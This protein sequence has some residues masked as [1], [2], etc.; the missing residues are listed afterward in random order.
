MGLN[1]Q[2]TDLGSKVRLDWTPDLSGQGYRLYIDG[3][4]VSRTFK[5]EA[6]ST[7]FTKPDANPHRY[8]VQKMDVVDALE[9]VEW[10][11]PPPVGNPIP[12]DGIIRAGGTYSGIFSKQ[13]RIS[14]T[15]PVIF[16]ELDHTYMDG[17]M[18][19]TG[20]TRFDL[21][22]RNCR[23]TGDVHRLIDA[24]SFKR[25]D[26]QHL[27]VEKTAGVTLVGDGDVTYMYS[28]H[29]NIQRVPGGVGN[30]IQLRIKQ[31]GIC[32]LG[33]NEI[34]NEYNKSNPEDLVSL[35]HSSA[36]HI[37]DSMFW[38]QFHPGNGAG[39]SQNGIT[40]DGYGG[41]TSNPIPVNDTVVERIQVVRALS[42]ALFPT[43]SGPVNRT[44]FIDNRYVN[45]GLLDDGVT[46]NYY[47]YQGMSVKTGGTDNQAHGNVLGAM[48]GTSQ[49]SGRGNDGNFSGEPRGDGNG[50]TTG[51]WVDN[52]HMAPVGG[53][54]TQ[55]ME[56][57]EWDRWEAKKAAAG[58]TVGA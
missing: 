26:L 17:T 35:Y 50:S 20:S 3:V 16:Q 34:V 28:R 1:P 44:R 52:T 58:V 51:A 36:A 33:W 45:A 41:S 56:E 27:T 23:F 42:I 29:H 48:K 53:T 9:E 5:P 24:D 31:A 14:T 37:F 11:A 21:T 38:G 10:P 40:L 22:A 4:A 2:V 43:S 32:E 57:A 46:R 13:I 47:G 15:A 12:A 49:G 7:T 39:S 55:A 25:L 18:I 6:K 19:V 30:F 54:I 8:G